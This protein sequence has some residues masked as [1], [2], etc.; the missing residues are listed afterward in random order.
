MITAFLVAIFVILAI[1]LI[2]LVFKIGRSKEDL[3]LHQ[4]ID[5]FSGELVKLYEKIGS[6]GRDSNEIL[7]LTK[8]FHDILKPTKARGVL[9]ESILENLLKDVLP[10]EVIIP[11]YGFSSGKKVDFA[12]KLPQGLVPIDAKFSMEV[13]K[14]YLEAQEPDK[15]RQKKT[16]IDSIKKRIEETSGYIFPDE[17]TTDFSFMYVP[18]EAVYYFIITQTS[19]LDYANDKKVFV[20]GPN[21]LYAYLKTIL[22]GF[23]ALKIEKQA[24]EIYNNLRRLDGDITTILQEYSIL[25]TH[26]KNTSAKYD[27]IR[28]KIERISLRIANISKD[29]TKSQSSS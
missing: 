15:E 2:I 8:S 21:T 20:V 14:N 28:R 16:C 1:I 10:G 22:V 27:D 17:G 9:G 6:L 29:E 12:V 7:N 23:K 11:Q 26:L 25:G 3:I 5:S 13:F 4:K 18:S 19:L 24:K